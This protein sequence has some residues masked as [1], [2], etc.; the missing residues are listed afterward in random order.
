MS[1][2]TVVIYTDGACSGNPGPGAWAAA[3]MA[4]GRCKEI[5]GYEPE[6]TNNRMELLGAIRAL[7]C[8]KR[9]SKVKLYSDSAYLVNAVRLGWLRSWQSNGWRSKSKTDVKNIDLWQALAVLLERHDVEL[10]KAEGHSGD[11]WNE[12]CDQQARALIKAHTS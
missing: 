7:E 6:T 3:L 11:A 4:G 12:R 2:G 8:L 1:D 5:G 10:I 9:P